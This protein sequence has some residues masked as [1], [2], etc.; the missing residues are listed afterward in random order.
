MTPFYRQ[1]PILLRKNPK[2]ALR[3]KDVTATQKFAAGG[4]KK[5][6]KG[7]ETRRL[8]HSLARMPLEKRLPPWS[9]K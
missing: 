7:K 8:Q 2:S 6:K 9:L 5:R 1:T 4:Q 3:G